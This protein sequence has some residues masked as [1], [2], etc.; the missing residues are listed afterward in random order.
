MSTLNKK[1]KSFSSTAV[2]P[3]APSNPLLIFPLY[4]F[5]FYFFSSTSYVNIYIMLYVYPIL[6]LPFFLWIRCS[7]VYVTRISTA[8]PKFLFCKLFKAFNMWN[9]KHLLIYLL[10]FFP[11]QPKNRVKLTF[12]WEKR[13]EALNFKLNIK[14]HNFE[15]FFFVFD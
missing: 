2:T 9:C 3:R 6:C 12:T 8:T 13:F 15:C 10:F 14:V 4:L 7:A 1:K 5:I 11:W